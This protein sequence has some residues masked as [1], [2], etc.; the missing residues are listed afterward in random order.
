MQDPF[1]Q[2]GASVAGQPEAAEE[3]EELRGL[4]AAGNTLS[5]WILVLKFSL[6]AKELNDAHLA[7]GRPELPISH[8][9]TE[10]R[11]LVGEQ[12]FKFLD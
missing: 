3:R 12:F 1:A 7:T 4:S 11:Q 6:A 5:G 2:P 10:C 9:R 8:V